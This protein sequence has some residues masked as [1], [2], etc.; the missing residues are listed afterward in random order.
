MRKLYLFL[1]QL[2]WIQR[3][4]ELIYLNKLLI[5]EEKGNLQMQFGSL[6]TKMILE[7][8]RILLKYKNVLR[9]SMELTSCNCSIYVLTFH[10]KELQNLL[11]QIRLSL[12]DTQQK[13]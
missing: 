2:T 4:N 5:E 7:A 1:I 12:I 13:H 9:E 6:L 11:S 8:E 10:L 3:R